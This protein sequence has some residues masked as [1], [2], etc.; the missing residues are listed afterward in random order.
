MSEMTEFKDEDQRSKWRTAFI[1][2]MDDS[3][4]VYVDHNPA[5][6][7][8]LLDRPATIDDAIFMLG[9]ALEEF[10]TDKIRAMVNEGMKA[11]LVQAA[12]MTEAQKR[13]G[14]NGV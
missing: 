12:R 2:V 14:E 1:V 11:M 9:M 10:K 3:G 6:F 7:K 13:G 8:N 4:R 5:N